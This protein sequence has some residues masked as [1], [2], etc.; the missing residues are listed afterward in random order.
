[1]DN[2]KELEDDND[3]KKHHSQVVF[4][5]IFDFFLNMLLWLRKI[6]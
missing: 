2:V 5:N 4:K 1:M 6:I 3:N